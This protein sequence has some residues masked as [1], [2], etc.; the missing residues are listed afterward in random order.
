M[1]PDPEEGFAEIGDAGWCETVAKQADRYHFKTDCTTR[2]VVI[3]TTTATA[4]VTA[5]ELKLRMCEYEFGPKP[6]VAPTNMLLP[7]IGMVFPSVVRI[8]TWS[9]GGIGKVGMELVDPY[10]I[11]TRHRPGSALQ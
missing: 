6:V 11:E 9:G 1:T 10:R 2:F 8:H 4:L 3:L 5:S 7:S